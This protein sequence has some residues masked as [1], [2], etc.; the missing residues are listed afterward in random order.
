MRGRLL[1]GCQMPFIESFPNPGFLTQAESDPMSPWAEQRDDDPGRTHAT[2]RG[3]NDTPGFCPV[4]MAWR[5][6]I[7]P[8]HRVPSIFLQDWLEKSTGNL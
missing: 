8:L 5:G 7:H 1:W 4:C 2:G 6:V 3:K